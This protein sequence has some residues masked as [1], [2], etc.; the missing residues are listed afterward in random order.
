M[1]GGYGGKVGAETCSEVWVVQKVHTLGQECSAV[2]VLEHGFHDFGDEK[3]LKGA[4]GKLEFSEDSLSKEVSNTKPII[5][6]LFLKKELLVEIL[7]PL[8]D[9]ECLTVIIQFEP[10]LYS[11]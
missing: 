5:F 9:H 3:G 4:S 10:V 8:P 11:Y 1:L 6:R 2:L 7:Q